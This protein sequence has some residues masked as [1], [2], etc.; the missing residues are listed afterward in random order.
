MWMAV[1]ADKYELPLSVGKSLRELG[2]Q[3]QARDNAL[4][5]LYQLKGKSN[6]PFNGYRYTVVFV[7]MKGEDD[8][9]DTTKCS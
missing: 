3:M 7:D 2:K 1:T 9:E 5:H 4:W 8:G 6:K